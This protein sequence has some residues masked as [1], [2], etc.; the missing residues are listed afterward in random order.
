MYKD[1]T[2]TRG[3]AHIYRAVSGQQLAQVQYWE[4]NAHNW[5]SSKQREEQLFK[6]EKMTPHSTLP[7]SGRYTQTGV[8]HSTK[9]LYYTEIVAQ[10]GTYTQEQNLKT[11]KP[12]PF[13]T[14]YPA[15]GFLYPFGYY[16]R[17]FCLECLFP[18]SRQLID[19]A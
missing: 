2:D 19:L 11:N 12:P 17:Y 13:I 8:S 6:E 7:I 18:V 5:L 1:G 16:W 14:V 9:G 4:E 3:T 15:S 10:R